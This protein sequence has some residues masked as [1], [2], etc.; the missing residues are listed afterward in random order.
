MGGFA[1]WLRRRGGLVHDGVDLFHDFGGGNRGV[2]AKK[3]IAEGEQLLLLPLGCTIRSA[4]PDESDG[5]RCGKCRGSSRAPEQHK[6][7]C[8]VA[9]CRPSV[10]YLRAEHPELSPFIT[11]VLLLMS[12]LAKRDTS[13]F[14]AYLDTLP[15]GDEVDCLLNWD[16]DSKALLKGAPPS[17][18]L[19][20]PPPAPSPCRPLQARPRPA[21]GP[22]GP[23]PQAARSRTPRGATPGASSSARWRPRWRPGPT[24]GRRAPPATLT[25]SGAPRRWCR[26]A[27]STSTRRTG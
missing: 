23:P 7:S 5:A 14:S 3:D 4:E 17:P 25:P 20:T 13:D 11:T 24:P 6:D 16:A 1:E 18:G 26:A 19:A 15:N 12:E 10:A 2:C 8:V 22:A 21:P 9:G 27:P